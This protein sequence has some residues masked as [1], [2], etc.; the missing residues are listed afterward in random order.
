MFIYRAV[1]NSI[2]F[3]ENSWTVER[4]VL[5]ERPVQLPFRGTKEEAETEAA[6]LNK[7]AR[8]GR[9]DATGSPVL[10]SPRSR[11]PLS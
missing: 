11:S 10:A 2:G 9:R 4:F 6:R 5:R 8:E 1:E 7:L 3:R